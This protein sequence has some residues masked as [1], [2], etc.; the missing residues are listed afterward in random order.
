MLPASALGS[1]SD[2][3]VRGWSVSS[4]TWS[5]FA[6]SR[7]RHSVYARR[8]VLACDLRCRFCDRRVRG[9]CPTAAPTAVRRAAGQVETR[10]RLPRE[11][12]NPRER[13]RLARRLVGAAL[14]HRCDQHLSLVSHLLLRHRADLRALL[15]TA[16]VAEQEQPRVVPGRE[17]AMHASS[18]DG[19]ATT[20]PSMVAPCAVCTVCEVSMLESPA[21]T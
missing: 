16:D 21:S 9:R 7:G 10:Q 3:R 19:R 12:D 5:C 18:S 15:V 8:R 11:P 2:L 14:A 4:P 1:S 6:D 17:A 13:K 20:V